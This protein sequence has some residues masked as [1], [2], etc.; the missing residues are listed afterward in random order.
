MRGGGRENTSSFDHFKMLKEEQGTSPAYSSVGTTASVSGDDEIAFT[1]M[2]LE[3]EETVSID[4]MNDRNASDE[5]RDEAANAQQRVEA[6]RWGEGSSTSSEHLQ[7][8]VKALSAVWPYASAFFVV[9]A[10]VLGT[11]KSILTLLYSTTHNGTLSTA[12]DGFWVL[13][14]VFRHLGTP[15]EAWGLWL[16]SFLLDVYHLSFDAGESKV[17]SINFLIHNCVSYFWLP[18]RLWCCSLL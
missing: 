13:C 8:A 6:L 4:Q 3:N 5:S 2:Q 14:A 17:F 12:T 7:M 10:S 18:A 16:C 9:V 11:G 1:D 15:S